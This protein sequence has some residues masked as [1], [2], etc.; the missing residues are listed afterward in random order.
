MKPLELWSEPVDLTALPSD[1]F[2]STMSEL[3]TQIGADLA[4]YEAPETQEKLMDLLTNAIKSVYG[5]AILSGNYELIIKALDF[6]HQFTKETPE[7][8]QKVVFDNSKEA[9]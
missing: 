5:L 3:L 9:L 2:F 1:S 7:A 8:V 4:K 6:I